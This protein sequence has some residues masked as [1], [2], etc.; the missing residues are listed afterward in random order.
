MAD[1][2]FHYCDV[3]CEKTENKERFM[4]M[5]VSIRQSNI[6]RVAPIVVITIC[7]YFLM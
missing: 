2:L 7:H 1:I 3:K 6:A 4:L 5:N